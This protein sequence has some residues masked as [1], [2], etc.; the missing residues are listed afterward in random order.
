MWVFFK[1]KI[2]EK[3]SIPVYLV[4]PPKHCESDQAQIGMQRILKKY[5]GETKIVNNKNMH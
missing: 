5:E 1:K 4:L 3:A 2:I